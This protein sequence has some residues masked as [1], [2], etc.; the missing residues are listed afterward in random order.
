V[1]PHTLL[2]IA[3]NTGYSDGYHLHLEI[4]EFENRLTEGIWEFKLIE[5][6]GNERW[7]QRTSINVRDAETRRQH[8]RN[9][10]YFFRNEITFRHQGCDEKWGNCKD[11]CIH[12]NR[13]WRNLNEI[14][15][16]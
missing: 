11:S 7:V 4:W 14:P 8:L 10:L 16:S 3:G 15:V 1:T 6:N 9:P 2:G 12:Y 13:L 5:T